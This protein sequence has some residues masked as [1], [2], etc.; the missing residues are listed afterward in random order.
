MLVVALAAATGANGERQLWLGGD[1]VPNVQCFHCT[2]GWIRFW[3]TRRACSMFRGP[4]RS[5]YESLSFFVGFVNRL[6]N[7]VWQLHSVLR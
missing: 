2:S 3:T 6:R 1:E 4:R 7:L 5:A